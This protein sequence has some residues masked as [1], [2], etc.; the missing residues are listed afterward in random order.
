MCSLSSF[1]L[2]NDVKSTV[3]NHYIIKI[4]LIIDILS[5]TGRNMLY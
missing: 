3:E 5:Q 2:I 4:V 1:I